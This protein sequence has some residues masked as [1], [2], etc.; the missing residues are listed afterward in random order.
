M[1]SR[2]R[3]QA[4]F[5]RKELGGLQQIKTDTAIPPRYRRILKRATLIPPSANP[6]FKRI[7][8]AEYDFQTFFFFKNK[9]LNNKAVNTNAMDNAPSKAKQMEY[10]MHPFSFRS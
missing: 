7:A 1:K 4:F 6:F 5:D 10:E 2:G 8:A 9:Q 3:V